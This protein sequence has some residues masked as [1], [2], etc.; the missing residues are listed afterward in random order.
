MIIAIVHVEDMDIVSYTILTKSLPLLIVDTP[1]RLDANSRAVMIATSAEQV[2]NIIF[3]HLL[4]VP[5]FSF[6]LP[7][8]AIDEPHIML[9]SPLLAATL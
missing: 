1:M 6:H 7:N 3:R 2:D 8:N 9:V 5:L 4:D